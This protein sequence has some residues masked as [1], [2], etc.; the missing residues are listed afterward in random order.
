MLMKKVWIIVFT[1][2]CLLGLNGC[3]PGSNQIDV[4]E[5]LNNTEKIELFQYKNTKPKLLRPSKWKTP[6]FNFSN[7]TLLATLDDSYI[8]DVVKDIAGEELLVFGKVLNEPIGKTMVL[9]QSDG[10]MLVL[11]GCLYKNEK[12]G[13]RY[14]GQ[15]ILF[16]E[17]GKY[18]EYLGNIDHDY[19]DK[20]ALKY[21]DSYS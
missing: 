11:F 18:I 7:A 12:G 8:E 20:L 5:I 9:Y 1:L 6:V 15:C 4:N 13:T 10:N 16:D 21:F 19:V 2:I 17:N 3:D 14:Y